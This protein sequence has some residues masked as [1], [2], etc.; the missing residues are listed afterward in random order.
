MVEKEQLRQLDGLEEDGGAGVGGVLCEH[1][2]KAVG[3]GFEA[4]MVIVR[5]PAVLLNAFPFAS[6]GFD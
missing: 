4:T 6:G 2:T 3:L 5:G 1:K